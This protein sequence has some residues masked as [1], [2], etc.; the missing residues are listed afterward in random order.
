MFAQVG[1]PERDHRHFALRLDVQSTLDGPHN[2]SSP[3]EG[4]G[5]IMLAGA[6]YCSK[7]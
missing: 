3:S 6:G 5:S 1:E 7:K 4:A 2:G